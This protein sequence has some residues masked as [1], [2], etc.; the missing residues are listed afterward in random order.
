MSGDIAAIGE[1]LITGE[2][3]EISQQSNTS[4]QIS[5]LAH[6][7]SIS[8]LHMS[9][10]AGGVF[11][12][13]RGLLALSPTLA[14]SFPIK[15]WA[16]LAALLI[17]FLYM[18]LSGSAVATQRS[19][20]MLAI[21][22][23]A[24]LLDRPALSTRNLAIAALLILVLEPEA[25][26]SASFQMSFLAVAGLVCFYDAWFSR[27]KESDRSLERNGGWRRWRG[28]LWRA[29]LIASATTLIAGTLSSIPALYHFGRAS[30]FSLLANLLATP[31]IG[32]VVM[33]MALASILLMPLGLDALPLQL[34]GEGL[35]VMLS[36][37]D[38]V[39]A[40]PSA[41]MMV[42]TLALS[43]VLLLALA[44]LM[45]C[46]LRGPPRWAGL[47]LLPVAF[48]CA[49]FRNEPDI[50]VERT[51]SNVAIRTETGH[52]A[53]ANTK[54]G[55]FAAEKWLQANGEEPRLTS[56]SGRLSWTC[57]K[58][59]CLAMVKAHRVV[60]LDDVAA[61]GGGCPPADI[62]IARFPLRDKC[63]GRLL[64]IDRFDVW[65]NG[66]YAI[67]LD[68]AGI[69]QRTSRSEQGRRPWTLAPIP[70]RDLDKEPP[71]AVQ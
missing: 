51:V 7:L 42:P 52:L 19:Y 16:A 1:A 15:K 11:A 53:F 14:L 41:R 39:A 2:R 31:V 60:Y 25:A 45:L 27:D 20:V 61:L 64:T 58:A 34:M 6:V 70:R 13:V 17:G 57:T 59:S 9:L 4:L 26:L 3:A 32:L 30:P 62:L 18:L 49:G 37:S 8:G 50:L 63:D 47:V 35:R 46:L 36:I 12:L 65:R 43:T 56:S 5:G 71:D 33:P 68:Q 38:W 54:R 67:Y 24:I 21:M 48:V 23:L 66:A 28:K 69:T 22:F 10:I 29:L 44:A 55:R 40:L